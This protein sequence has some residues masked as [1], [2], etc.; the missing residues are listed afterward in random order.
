MFLG[1]SPGASEFVELVSVQ[2]PG[3]ILGSLTQHEASTSLETLTKH[4]QLEE[5]VSLWFDP[6]SAHP[7]I[8][9][10]LIFWEIS[11]AFGAGEGQPEGTAAQSPIGDEESTVTPELT[12]RWL[13]FNLLSPWQKGCLHNNSKSIKEKAAHSE[14][15]HDGIQ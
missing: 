1:A 11:S 12:A 4:Q 14:A 10:L 9:L 15:F 8:N 2:R 3:Y 5:P 13:L 7:Y 6:R